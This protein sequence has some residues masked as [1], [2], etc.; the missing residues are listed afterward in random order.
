[1]PGKQQLSLLYAVAIYAA[2]SSSVQAAPD[3]N[4]Y[5]PGQ[6]SD[7]L[8]KKIRIQAVL[9]SLHCGTQGHLP[10]ECLLGGIL[11][12]RGPS[13]MNGLV[14]YRCIVNYKFVPGKA[15]GVQLNLQRNAEDL[16]KTQSTEQGV[17]P[18]EKNRQWRNPAGI[19]RTDTKTEITRNK[20]I[21]YHYGSL[22][23]QNGQAEHNLAGSLPLRL[24][25]NASQIV[26]E[27]LS[28]SPE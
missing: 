16:P 13:D 25:E 6:D 5:P 8:Q 10:N 17:G 20:G 22:T 18:Q 27:D 14:R 28:C 12:V 7:Q 4:F 9:P 21:A 1:M 24:L 2:M 3:L 19:D 26:L 23:L 15:G 11:R